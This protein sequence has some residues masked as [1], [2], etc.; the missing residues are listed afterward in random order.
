M[1]VRVCVFVLG[2]HEGVLVLNGSKLKTWER[3][4]NSLC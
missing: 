4:S 1:Y 3:G 2:V